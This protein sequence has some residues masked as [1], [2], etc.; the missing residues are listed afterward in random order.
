MVKDCDFDNTELIMKSSGPYFK[1]KFD[2][3]GRFIAGASLEDT[4]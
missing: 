1:I 2:S 3:T 4:L